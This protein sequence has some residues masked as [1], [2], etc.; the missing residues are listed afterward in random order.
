MS[1]YISITVLYLNDIAIPKLKRQRHSS[2]KIF[3]LCGLCCL[4]L[5]LCIVVLMYE[6]EIKHEFFVEK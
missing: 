6:I 5:C 1:L 4:L 3:G 2:I